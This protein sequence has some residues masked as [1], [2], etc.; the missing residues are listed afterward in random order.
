MLKSK[1]K[2]KLLKQL[3]FG[4]T[5]N[6]VWFEKRLHRRKLTF[7]SSSHR[8]SLL[9]QPSLQVRC[10]HS[11]GKVKT[12]CTERSASVAAHYI[13]GQQNSQGV[14]ADVQ[15]VRV[16]ELRNVAN[17]SATVI[18]STHFICTFFFIDV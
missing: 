15:S 4:D 5:F 13:G 7:C 12:W 8:R 17:A 16:L 11:G 10:R 6:K 14:L 2:F 1:S 3:Q 9:H 18:N